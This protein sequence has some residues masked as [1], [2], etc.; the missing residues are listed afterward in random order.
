MV[1]SKRRLESDESEEEQKEVLVAS[2]SQLNAGSA[3]KV[4]SSISHRTHHPCIDAAHSRLQRARLAT[5]GNGHTSPASV[6]TRIRP[7]E[8]DDEGEDVDELA[9]PAPQ[10]APSH[11]AATRSRNGN[12]DISMQEDGSDDE[13]GDNRDGE[14]ES[15]SDDDGDDVRDKAMSGKNS[16]KGV[17]RRC[18]TLLKRLA[19]AAMQC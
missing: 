15:E 17:R 11:K 10:T 12:A 18:L 14:G 3:S 13:E 9:T 6:L 5:N 19:V 1:N 4:R 7:E 2:S 8:S 16:Q